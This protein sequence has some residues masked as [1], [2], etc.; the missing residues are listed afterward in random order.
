MLHS[1]VARV[2]TNFAFFLALLIAVAHIGLCGV[3]AATR[4]TVGPVSGST[5]EQRRIADWRVCR[6]GTRARVWQCRRCC[7]PA[8]SRRIHLCRD[9]AVSALRHMSGGAMAAGPLLHANRR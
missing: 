2:R 9:L 6:N 8:R 1:F 7:H 4:R 5:P 3:Q